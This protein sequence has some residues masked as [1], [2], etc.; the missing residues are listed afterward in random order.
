[1]LLLR[2]PTHRRRRRRTCNTTHQN[3]IVA[4][5]TKKGG[6]GT[7]SKGGKPAPA[8]ISGRKTLRCVGVAHALRAGRVRPAQPQRPVQHRSLHCMQLVASLSHMLEPC[9]ARRLPRG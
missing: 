8:P 3:T 5:L 7:T 1:M 6:T 4:R 2:R 9:R